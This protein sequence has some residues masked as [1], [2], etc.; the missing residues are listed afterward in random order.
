MPAFHPAPFDTRVIAGALPQYEKVVYSPPDDLDSTYFDT[1]NYHRK[2]EEIDTLAATLTEPTIQPKPAGTR[3]KW[4][5][6]DP[7]L[8]NFKSSPDLLQ[9]PEERPKL[10]RETTTILDSPE[11]NLDRRQTR[12]QKGSRSLNR[13][14]A[15]I[16]VN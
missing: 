8:K 12:F 13:L 5:L 2:V 10:A 11:F 3:R 4:N 15:F 7:G 6:L 14:R 1:I 9:I 16:E